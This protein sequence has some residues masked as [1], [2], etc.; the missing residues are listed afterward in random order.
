MN[1]YAGPCPGLPVNF[2]GAP[3]FANVGHKRFNLK[4]I[5]WNVFYINNGMR[6]HF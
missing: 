6:K 2:K 1:V 3:K 5:V 4:K